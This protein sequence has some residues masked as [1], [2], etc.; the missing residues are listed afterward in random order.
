MFFS[1]SL[2]QNNILSLKDV[3]VHALLYV[4]VYYAMY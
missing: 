3:S 1:E 4:K 2:E